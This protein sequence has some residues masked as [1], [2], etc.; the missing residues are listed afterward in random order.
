MSA[1]YC[2]TAEDLGAGPEEPVGCG[3]TFTFGGDTRPRVDP[4][5]TLTWAWCPDCVR[6]EESG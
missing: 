4:A 3:V 5:L 1:L 2:P 6:G